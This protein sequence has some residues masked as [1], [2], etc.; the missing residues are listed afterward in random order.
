M[1]N[2]NF[3]KKNFKELALFGADDEELNSHFSA[4]KTYDQSA[5]DADKSGIEV[6][7]GAPRRNR[8]KVF[9]KKDLGPVDLVK[10]H[11][12]H[13]VD[14]QAVLKGKVDK[15]TDLWLRE[16]QQKNTGQK[17]LLGVNECAHDA[18]YDSTYSTGPAFN[19]KESFL[20][21]LFLMR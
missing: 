18:E 1:E 16:V 7:I 15:T 3:N 9:E 4:E 21:H 6:K 12:N 10:I 11:H 13:E 2:E 17:I 8:G 19:P 14:L 20:T 5:I